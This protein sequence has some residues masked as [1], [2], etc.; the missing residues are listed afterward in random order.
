[1][2]EKLILARRNL[3]KNKKNTADKELIFDLQDELDHLLL[4][5]EALSCSSSDL[6]GQLPVFTYTPLKT[7]PLPE[8][9]FEKII[10]K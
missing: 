3:M 8:S 1:M 9:L 4:Q 10:P 6:I 2:R 7:Q 5:A